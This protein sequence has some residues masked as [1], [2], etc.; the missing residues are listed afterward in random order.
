MLTGKQITD[1]NKSDIE[2]G[3]SFFTMFLSIFAL[4]AI[5]VGSFIIFNVF[6]ISAAQRQQENA[7]LR[8]IGASRGQVTRSL[9]VEALVVGIG[10]SLIGFVAG[11]G[12]ATAILELLSQSRLRRRRRAAW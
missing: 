11:I 1:E 6:S 10:G 9:L 4:I 8:A 7:L 5:F 3:L 12:L 2:R